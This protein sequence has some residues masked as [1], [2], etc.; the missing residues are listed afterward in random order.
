MTS[1]LAA[2][3]VP[4]RSRLLQFKTSSHQPSL[5]GCNVIFVLRVHFIQNRYPNILCVSSKLGGGKNT[6]VRPRFGWQRTGNAIP[7]FRMQSPL[8]RRPHFS[9]P[10]L[11]ER[12]FFY[13]FALFDRKK[14]PPQY[15][16]LSVQK[17]KFTAF[18]FINNY[19]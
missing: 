14:V 2:G 7:M 19:I 17:L 15:F 1:P 11:W 3:T 18:S 5:N 10:S 9:H 4:T 6:I 16:C 12:H 8:C 13:L